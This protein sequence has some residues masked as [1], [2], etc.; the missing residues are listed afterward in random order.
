MKNDDCSAV[1]ICAADDP[2]D[3]SPKDNKIT[4]RTN[5]DNTTVFGDGGIIPYIKRLD[6]TYEFTLSSSHAALVR[7]ML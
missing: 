7:V 3:K 1:L 2:T 5:G 6:G 4:F